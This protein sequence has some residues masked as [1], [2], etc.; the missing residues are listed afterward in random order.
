VLTL[1]DVLTA[2][3]GA[4][5]VAFDIGTS[6]NPTRFEAL[7]CSTK[8][9]QTVTRDEEL[10]AAGFPHVSLGCRTIRDL[11]GLAALV[12]LLRR[13]RID[14]LHAH[15]WDS[16]LWAAL[17]GPLARTPVV[18][19]HE[20][21]WSFEGQRLRVASDRIIIARRATAVV[22]VS[23][24]D[25][26][27]MV[28]IERIPAERI[29][30]LPN[31]IAPLPPPSTDLR[32]ELG[33][34]ADVPVVGVVAVLRRQ[35]RLDILIEALARVARRVPGVQ[36]VIAGEATENLGETLAGLASEIGIRD[37]VHFL[38][39]HADVAGVLAGCDVACLSSDYEGQP[40]AVLEYMDAGKPIV[41]TRVGGIPELIVDGREGILV[42]RRDPEALAAALARVL[43]DKDLAASL[44][45]AARERQRR[46]FSL[47]AA[48]ARVEAL[49]DELWDT[50]QRTR[51]G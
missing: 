28:E 50:V 3:G 7:F 44:G 47:E 17:A 25:K 5:R 29:R 19:A 34:A 22:C 20:H 6:L 10:A 16:N 8:R 27:K 15:L 26:R 1:I 35:K 18:I 38:G 4:E 42:P 9:S 48:V 36:L 14:I 11:R 37:R 51:N 32:A 45:T 2:A 46:E 13:E 41:A 24:E 43:L 49:Y 39:Y 33:L 31:G 23:D 12:R 30:V 40:L 21:T